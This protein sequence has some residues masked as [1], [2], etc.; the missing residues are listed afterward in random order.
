M[1]KMADLELDIQMML[2]DGFGEVNLE[3][4]FALMQRIVLENC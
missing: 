1:S 4:M 3:E 2:K